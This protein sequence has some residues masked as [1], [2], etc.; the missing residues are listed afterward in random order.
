MGMAFHNNELIET[1]W[2]VNE[3][4]VRE[5]ESPSREL[6]ETLWNVN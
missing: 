2:N 5:I 6:I 3:Y 4:A 1:L